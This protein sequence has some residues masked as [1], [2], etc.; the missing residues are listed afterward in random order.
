MKSF[1]PYYTKGSTRSKTHL[2]CCFPSFSNSEVFHCVSVY[3][4]H[5]WKKFSF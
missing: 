3:N 4:L 2:Y 1:R 5:H